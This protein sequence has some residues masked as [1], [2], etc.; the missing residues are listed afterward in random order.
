MAFVTTRILGTP[1]G[2]FLQ[3]GNDIS[4][5][6]ETTRWKGIMHLDTEAKKARTWLLG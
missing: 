4:N 6:A 5:L 2:V 1:E 3:A